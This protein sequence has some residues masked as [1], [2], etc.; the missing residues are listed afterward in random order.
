MIKSTHKASR[1]LQSVL[2][3]AFQDFPQLILNLHSY[4]VCFNCD[5]VQPSAIKIQV[6]RLFQSLREASELP[7]VPLA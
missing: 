4:I 1:L 6:P 5:N 3:R 7:D 2:P